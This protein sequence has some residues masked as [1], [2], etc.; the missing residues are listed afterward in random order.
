MIAGSLAKTNKRS[1]LRRRGSHRRRRERSGKRGPSQG[2]ASPGLTRTRRANGVAS[3][4]LYAGAGYGAFWIPELQDEVLVAFI[5]GDMRQPI[6][7]GGL[8]NGVDKP[9]S[10]RADDKDEKVLAP[11]RDTK[12]ALSTPRVKSNHDRRQER[13]TYD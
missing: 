2:A 13:F 1:L 12:F 4:R 6:V 11:K 10:H 8:Y 7:V 5:H 9:P 3:V